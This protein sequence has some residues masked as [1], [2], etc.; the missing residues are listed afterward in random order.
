MCLLN[1]HKS[2]VIYNDKM[3]YNMREKTLIL[4][5]NCNQ[6]RILKVKS[7]IDLYYH[8]PENIAVP[9]KRNT[10]LQGWK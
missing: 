3:K 1:E 8:F 9:K 4:Y 6:Q 10:E 5:I 2:L 7:K